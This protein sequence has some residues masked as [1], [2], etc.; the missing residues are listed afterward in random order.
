M[1]RSWCQ[2][3]NQQCNA[4][5]L[6]AYFLLSFYYIDLW[7]LKTIVEWRISVWG[8]D[9]PQKSFQKTFHH[10]VHDKLPV[11]SGSWQMPNVLLW[12]KLVEFIEV[13]QSIYTHINKAMACFSWLL[14]RQ[15]WQ[16]TNS[17]VVV[18]QQA[19]SLNLS[20][21]GISLLV[22]KKTKSFCTLYKKTEIL[23][24]LFQHCLWALK[25]L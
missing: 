5:S 23:V 6:L 10:L 4:H 12:K 18:S 9:I 3:E 20:L 19:P 11:F 7:E 15:V 1:R 25:F 17:V 13:T 2:R 22:G 8:I 21:K 14:D 16:E 24:V